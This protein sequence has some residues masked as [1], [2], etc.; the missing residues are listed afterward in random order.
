MEL[1]DEYLARLRPII[2]HFSDE[3]LDR[4]SEG[5]GPRLYVLVDGLGLPV[6][7][8]IYDPVTGRREKVRFIPWT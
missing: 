8:L 2:D 6:Q 1:D 7:G 5:G 3:D 4:L